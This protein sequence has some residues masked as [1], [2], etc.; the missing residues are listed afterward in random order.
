MNQSFSYKAIIYSF[1]RPFE[2]NWWWPFAQR[3]QTYASSDH[4][5]LFFPDP[6]MYTSLE[7]HTRAYIYTS[8]RLLLFYWLQ[9]KKRFDIDGNSQ[10]TFLMY[11]FFILH[12][13]S[14]FFSFKAW[15]NKSAL[16]HISCIALL[17]TL[18]SESMYFHSIRIYQ[19]ILRRIF[20]DVIKVKIFE[21]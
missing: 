3:K 19:I 17:V 9:K 5:F 11:N 14:T 12:F 18:K 15:V 4:L 13:H 1:R 16:S 7:P 21:N 2:R 8:V 20:I 10:L 6:M